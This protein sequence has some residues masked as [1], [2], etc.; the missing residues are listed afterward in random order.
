MRHVNCVVR[1]ICFSLLM[2]CCLDGSQVVAADT[3]C[4]VPPFFVAVDAPTLDDVPGLMQVSLNEGYFTVANVICLVRQLKRDHGS[5]AL[6]V[7]VFDSRY[8]ADEFVP[9]EIERSGS[10]IRSHKQ[11]RARYEFNPRTN[12]EHVDLTPLGFGRDLQFDTRIDLTADTEQQ[13]RFTLAG[14]CL[15]AFETMEE[16]ESLS[17][18]PVGPI[19]LIGV[20]GRDGKIVRV[21]IATTARRQSSGRD[22]FIRAAVSNLKAWRFE[23]GPRIETIR[24]TYVLADTTVADVA[25]ATLRI[26][27]SNDIAVSALTITSTR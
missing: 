1:G 3:S 4:T 21:R 19:T 17:A 9:S 20:V 11:L 14:R 22:R 12:D 27:L 2:A 5:K 10:L 13:C 7:L 24:V 15:L 25:K 23:V 6:T 8:A 16:L 26:R 18:R